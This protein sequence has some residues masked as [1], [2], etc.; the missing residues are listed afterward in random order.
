MTKTSSA[1]TTGMPQPRT[2]RAEIAERAIRQVTSFYDATIGSIFSEIYQNAR[3][4]GATQVRVDIDRD[5]QTVTVTDDGVG[6]ASPE[7]VLSF[8]RS[9]WDGH[10]DEHPAGMGLY[11]L[12]RRGAHISS[13][14]RGGCAAW[15]TFLEPKHFRGDEAAVVENLEVTGP[16][17]TTITFPIAE[18]DDCPETAALTQARY[19]PIR[20]TISGTS[21]PQE[22]FMAPSRLAGIVEESDLVFGI[23]K[24]DPWINGP[25]T[26]D[27]TINFHRHVVTDDVRTPVVRGLDSWWT[28]TIEVKHCPE[29]ELVLPAREKIIRNSY[30]TRLVERMERA[31]YQVIAEQPT[32]QSLIFEHAQ[33]ASELGFDIE[34]TKNVLVEWAQM[35]ADPDWHGYPERTIAPTPPDAIVVARNLNGSQTGML[36]RALA[37]EEEDLQRAGND[38]GTGTRRRLFAETTAFEGFAWYDDMPKAVDLQVEIEVD[39]E[40][41]RVDPADTTNRIADKVWAVLSVRRPDETIETI[42]IETDMGLSCDD[43]A[44]YPTAAGLILSRSLKSSRQAIEHAVDRALFVAS[45]NCADGPTTQNTE[46]LTDLEIEMTTLLDGC[47]TALETAIRNALAY[48]PAAPAGTTVHMASVD[49]KTWKIETH[50]PENSGKPHGQPENTTA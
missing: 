7:A 32:P 48:I 42:R 8:G 50:L 24:R 19:L 35:P 11:S 6:I 13:R 39:G 41:S 14:T 25:T 22:P 45:D 9:D 12:S 38:L 4:A 29:L 33:R 2:I 31:I 15:Q 1:T 43:E 34:V 37:C 5:Q 10:G 30:L 17:G 23:C 3:R 18:N 36:E 44:R 26:H 47:D 40:R 28:T 21:V 49:G 16:T 46:F 20:V 27:L